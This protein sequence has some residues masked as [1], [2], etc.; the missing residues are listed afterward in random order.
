[1]NKLTGRQFRLPTEAEWEYAARGGRSNGKT[2]SGSN[3]IETVAWYKS[4]SVTK[5]KSGKSL[6]PHS[7]KSKS[8]NELGLYDMSGNV[9]EWCQDWYDSDYYKKSPSINPQG[10]ICDFGRVC[11]GGC[12][13]NEASECRV[14]ARYFFEPKDKVFFVG[15]RLAL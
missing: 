13:V 1:M 5:Y 15:L 3:D 14:A 11:R 4:N 8:P 7:V 12:S 10:P 9:Y 6:L 2:Y